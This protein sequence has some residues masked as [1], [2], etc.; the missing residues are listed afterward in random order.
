[1]M[2]SLS[3]LQDGMVAGSR[4]FKILDQTEFA[5]Q[6]NPGADRQITAGKVEFK[7]V[8]FSYDGQ[9]EILHDI[10]FVAQPGQTVALVGHT[11]SGKSSII[12]VM[13]RFYEFYEGQILIDGYDIRD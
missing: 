10:S 6:P 9:H 4:I 3:S 13:M 7:H 2:D 11:G 5:P 8:S 1:M 12:N